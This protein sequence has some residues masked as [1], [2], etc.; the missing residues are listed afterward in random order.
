MAAAD[1]SIVHR[2][3][4]LC[5]AT[6]GLRVHTAADDGG[7][8]RVTRVEGDPDDAFSKGHIC[9]KAHALIE[10]QADPDRLRTPV[11]KTAKGFE[12]IGWDE[13]LDLAAEKL[14]AIRAE[15]GADAIALYRGNPTTHDAQ[16]L[17]YWNVLQ[18]ALPTRS[19]FSAGSVDTWPRWVQA[20][21]MYG[22]F[23]NTPVPDLA[24]CDYLLMLGAN[25]LASNGSLMTAPG[26]KKR[27]EA[28]RARG[29]R[30]VVVDPR[31]TETAAIADEHLFVRPGGDAALVLAMVQVVVEEE[32]VDLG[33]AE[34]L[35][36]GL[37]RALTAIRPYTPERVTEACGVAPETIRRIA[38]EVAEADRAVVYGRM[39]TSVQTFGTLAHWAIDLLNILTGNLDREGGVLF[40]LPAA[41]LAFAGPS[42]ASG[43]EVGRAKSPVSGYDEVLGEWPMA[44]F[45][46]EIESD[47]EDRIRAL[48]IIAGNPVA[49]APNAERVDAALERLEFMVAFDYY[50]NETTRHA[51]LILPPTAPLSH[52]T[53]DV[54]LLHFAVENVAKWS[55]AAVP[56]EEGEQEVWR[57]LLGL[58]KRLMGLGGMA[59][60][61]V[62]A[63]VVAQ[64]AGRVLAGS[65]FAGEIEVEEI[66]SGLGDTPGP[67]RLIDLLLR[68]GAYGDGFGRVPDG[69]SVDRLEAAPHGLSLGTPAPRLP[70]ALETKSGRIDLAP[71]RI[72][73]DLPR[74]ERFVDAGP[75]P[76]LSL[77]GRRDIRSMNSWLHNLPSMVKG[78]ERCTLQV[79]PPDAERL[80]L[81]TGDRAELKG[82]VGAIVVPVEVTDAMAEGVVSLPHGWGH[83]LPGVRLSVATARPGA[84]ANR[85]VDDAEIDVP[86]G[87][88]VLNGVPVE[89][90]RV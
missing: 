51:D 80:G 40:P 12:P 30:L 57:T 37:D 69:L 4:T 53:Y 52:A 35:V 18:T 5:E 27:L 76:R 81:S 78:R 22:G 17:L 64:L 31:R 77:I 25:P 54:A 19:Q 71:D 48:A 3:C 13:A 41:S 89:V 73:G 68:L 6:C 39:G 9:P 34:G 44:A 58:S 47:R 14:G 63:I 1:P 33:R 20:G 82:R 56:P 74:L 29:G 49:S 10:L 62:D 86:S 72:L 87:T 23:L 70:E 90:T 26:I 36:E 28:I 46:E 15:A 79:A 88:S 42:K 67:R 7:G 61:E 38:R 65:R 85:V 60:D 55:P 32:R 50:V 16:S 75:D 83:D 24:R 66:V 84:N 21:L 8:R 43:F 45:A 59:D 11:R 2:I